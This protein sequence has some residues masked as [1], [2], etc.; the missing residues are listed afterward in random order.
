MTTNTYDRTDMIRR[1]SVL[2]AGPMKLAAY[3]VRDP[4]TD[5]F[6]SL[7]F[8]MTFDNTV[9]A[10]MGEAPARLFADFVTRTLSPAQAQPSGNPN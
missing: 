9:L 7:Q 8:H 2:N 3:R 1:E 4:V 6:G 5:E 10:V